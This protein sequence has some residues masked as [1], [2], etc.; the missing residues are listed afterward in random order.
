MTELKSKIK[1]STVIT[2]LLIVTSV[3]KIS[4]TQT[5]EKPIE[6]NVSPVQELLKRGQTSAVV[7]KFKIP[8][9]FWLGNEDKSTRIPAPTII[10]LADNPYL[11]F[12]KPRF[13]K[14]SVKGVPVHNGI[15]KVYT[16]EV[17]VIVPFKVKYDALLGEY[18]VKIFLTYT[19]GLNA[20]HLTTHIKEPYTTVVKIVDENPEM[21]HSIPAPSQKPVSS[22]FYIREKEIQLPEPLKTMFHRWDENGPV[23]KFL[24]CLFVDPENHG[25]HIQTVWT[26]FVGSTENNGRSVGLGVALMNVTREG[27]MTGTVQLRGYYN[28]YVGAT[29]ALELVSC[30]GAYFN[31]W[32]SAQI[33]EDKNKQFHFHHEN[34]TV[35]KHDRIGY[36]MQ[37]DLGEDSRYRFYGLGANTKED[38]QSNYTHEEYGGFF[39]FYFL[40]VDHLRLSVGAKVRSVNVKIGAERLADEMP[41]TVN[42]AKF[43]NVPGITGATVFGQRFNVV[44]DHRNQEFTPSD[45]FYGKLTLEYNQVTSDPKPVATYGKFNL[46]LRQY[47]STADQKFTLLLRNEWTLTTS[48]DIP[49]F[50]QAT[51]GGERSLRAFD[52]GR[53]YGKYSVF[54][55]VEL[56]YQA[57]HKV[58]MGFPMDLELAPFIDFGQVFNTFNFA[59]KFNFNPGLSL[60]ILNRPN[61]G[62]VANAAVGQDG[63]IF[64]GG[65]GLPL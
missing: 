24:H 11:I 18:V 40:P 63:V 39:D 52:T 5:I 8:Q 9:G 27:I 6:I 64:T 50:E 55:S 33:S 1:L 15:T 30:P 22:D 10:E 61:I 19:P 25:K 36:E 12:E 20:G 4:F 16:G 57:M 65:V 49:F 53:F 47:L 56:R 60:R 29:A 21:Q 45:G 51:L 2:I 23:P 7:I 3:N 62:I 31:Y 34:L 17:E 48:R 14:P 58:L 28:Q 35:G 13:P 42:L 44:Y 32:L 59:G 38:D 37:I 46:E 43:N 54:G 26:P 41:Y